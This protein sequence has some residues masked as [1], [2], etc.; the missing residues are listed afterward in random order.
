MVEFIFSAQMM[1]M[2][3]GLAI[4]GGRPALSV[5]SFLLILHV[6]PLSGAF[7]W[8]NYAP[9]TIARIISIHEDV[10]GSDALL[11]N[12]TDEKYRVT[13]TYLG[14]KR[15][16]EEA[17][18]KHIFDGVKTVGLDSQLISWFKHEIHLSEGAH[19]YWLPIQEVL[20]PHLAKELSSGDA[21]DLYIMWIGYTGTGW[22][23]LINEFQKA[24]TVQ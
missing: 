17:A 23:F 10:Q 3:K 13:V 11:V 20:L 1:G 9:A 16:I 22:V 18:R 21:V 2:A 5:F 8:E 24:R 12:T 4:V 15:P 7:S 19:S 14:E 6:P